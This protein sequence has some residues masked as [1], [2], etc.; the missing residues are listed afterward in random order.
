[1]CWVRPGVLDAK[2]RR[3][4]CASVLTAVDLPALERPT[5]AISGS[6]RGARSCAS[7][8]PS[9]AS[10]EPASPSGAPTSASSRNSSNSSSPAA[11][12]RAWAS[13]GSTPLTGRCLSWLA[14][15]RKR[16]V[17]VHASARLPAVS[18][19]V[20]AGLTG[21]GRP[22]ALSFSLALA[23]ALAAARWPVLPG[24]GFFFAPPARPA[25]RPAGFPGAAGAGFLLESVIA[26]RGSKEVP[27]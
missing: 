26:L 15:V 2:A 23:R 27:L 14:V 20:L 6:W 18:G 5:K 19:S 22:C 3:F 10:A 4:C 8:S 12:A 16:A 7:A 1:M 25:P 21:G 11:S 13:A 9:L 17:C 24:P